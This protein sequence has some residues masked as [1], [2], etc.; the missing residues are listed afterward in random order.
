MLLVQRLLSSGPEELVMETWTHWPY[1]SITAYTSER[2][3]ERREMDEVL[4]HNKTYT[5]NSRRLY[6]WLMFTWWQTGAGDTLIHTVDVVME[7]T[8]GWAHHANPWACGQGVQV[9]TV[10]VAH[11][12]AILHDGSSTVK[13]G[14]YYCYFHMVLSWPEKPHLNISHLI[15]FSFFLIL[16]KNTFALC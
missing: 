3:T 13:K 5:L 11:C 1:R 2:E 8:T 6:L 14:D 12:V 4:A 15:G 9:T 16:D 7:V 10:I